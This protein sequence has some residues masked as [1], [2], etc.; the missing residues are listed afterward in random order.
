MAAAA[1]SG[2]VFQPGPWY[3]ALA[4]PPGTP[5]DIVFPIVWTLLYIA[6]V[7]AAALVYRAA[8]AG[9]ALGWFGVQLGLNA[10]WSPVVFGAHWPAPGLLVIVALWL[11]LAATVRAFHAVR[12]VAAW[13]LAPYLVWVAYAAYLN[14]GLLIL[15]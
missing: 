7:V 14:A 8:G 10:A 3:A 9:R 15:N 5:P 4:K 2:A 6:M 1:S 13:L 12:P 11:A